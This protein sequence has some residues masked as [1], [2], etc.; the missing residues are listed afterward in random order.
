MILTE[1]ISRYKFVAEKS[2]G[3][4]LLLIISQSDPNVIVMIQRANE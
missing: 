4:V 1:S 2:R 3:G